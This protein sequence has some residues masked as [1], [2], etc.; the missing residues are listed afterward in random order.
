MT[1]TW[2]LQITLPYLPP[3]EFSRNSRAHWSALHEVQARVQDDVYALLL[4]AGW[5]D[6]AW[7]KAIVTMTFVLP[8]RI[9]RDGDNLITAAKP[10]LDAL[11]S[12]GVIVD[13]S[14]SVIGIANYRYEYSPDKKSTTIIKVERLKNDA[15]RDHGSD[16]GGESLPGVKDQNDGDT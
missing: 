1:R 8:N 15:R 5:S 12:C 4:E 11:V 6:T 10:I 9:R 2:S 13:D 7:Q 3:Q 14:L 16:H